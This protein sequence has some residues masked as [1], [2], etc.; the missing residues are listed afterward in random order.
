MLSYYL[1]ADIIF[2][3]PGLQALSDEI[4]RERED[5]AIHIIFTADGDSTSNP[6]TQDDRIIG[7]A[8][9]NLWYMI[10]DSSGIVMQVEL[11]SLLNY[12]VSNIL[13]NLFCV[14]NRYYRCGH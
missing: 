2:D 11:L 1:Y 13:S 14:G 9:V 12:V 10:E 8:T 4:S 6:D 3:R 7:M 5:L